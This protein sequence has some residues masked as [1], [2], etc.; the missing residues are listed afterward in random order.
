[1][2]QDFRSGS[3]AK[4]IRA[5]ELIVERKEVVSDEEF[6]VQIDAGMKLFVNRP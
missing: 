1:M 6:V 3:L 2:G 4:Q 5:S